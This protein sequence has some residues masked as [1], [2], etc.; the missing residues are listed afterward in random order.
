MRGVMYF[1]LYCIDNPNKGDV[2][3]AT[4]AA[5]LDYVADSGEMVS[6]A[7]PLLADDGKTMIGSLIILNVA[8]R[9]TAES[10]AHHDPYALAGLFARVELRPW[11]WLIGAPAD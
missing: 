2:R 1:A 11:K 6:V 10:W 9:T 5:H 8:D 4:R 3:Q 7:G